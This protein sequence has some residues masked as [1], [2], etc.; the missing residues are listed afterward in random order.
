MIAAKPN[1]DGMV[2]NN[3]R[4]TIVGGYSKT[5][6]PNKSAPAQK[7]RESVIIM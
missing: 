7:K 6:M 5:N 2:P 4:K 1:I 3:D